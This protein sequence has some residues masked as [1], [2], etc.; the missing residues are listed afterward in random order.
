[1]NKLFPILIILAFAAGCSSTGKTLKNSDA[2]AEIKSEFI[3]YYDLIVNRE[4]AKAMEYIVPEFF[5]IMP[6]EEMIGAMEQLFNDPKFSFELRPPEI[7]E[8]TKVVK[9]EGKWYAK[10]RYSNW[11]NMKIAGEANETADEKADRI[12][13]LLGIFKT[14]FGPDN[15][16][17]NEETGFFEIFSIKEAIAVSKNGK[18]DWKFITIEENQKLLIEKI[19]PAKV[20]NLE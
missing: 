14:N 15:V 8:V 9:E 19:I 1:M 5:E 6:K 7:K 3:A 10:L 11:M 18:S 4:F 16:I 13:M 12:A 20:L 2:K 17:Y